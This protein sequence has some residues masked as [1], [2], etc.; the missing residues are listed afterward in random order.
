VDKSGDSWFLLDPSQPVWHIQSTG[1]T[2]TAES[3]KNDA[4]R[5]TG[6]VKFE[7]TEAAAERPVR[8]RYRRRIPRDEVSPRT[9]AFRG[10]KRTLRAN[11]SAGGAGKS[12]VSVEALRSGNSKATDSH[13][14]TPGR[15]SDCGCRSTRGL[16]DF[17]SSSL[18]LRR[19]VARS[20]STKRCTQLW[21]LSN[22]GRSL[23]EALRRSVA[24]SFSTKRC[25]QLFD[26]AL[27][28]AFGWR[29]TTHG[30]V[31]TH[32]PARASR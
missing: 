29:A 21:D 28:A 25:T 10:R 2:A 18:A 11:L 5:A 6:H 23:P 9:E 16:C 19:S 7:A 26:D 27:H 32:H 13:G 20:F 15:E 3:A 14:T 4:N 22:R 8:K 17:C 12:V 24:R 1:R 30:W 31:T